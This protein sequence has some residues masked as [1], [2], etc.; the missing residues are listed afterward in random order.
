MMS[1]EIT[2]L[3]AFGGG[4][5]SFLSP[6]VVPLVPSYI[7]VLLGEHADKKSRAQL[8]ILALVFVASFSTVFILLGLSASFIGQI[9]LEHLMLLRK[10]SGIAVIILGIHLTG[11][12]KVNFL[13]REKRLNFSQKGNSYLRALVMGL[14]LS[15]AWTPCIGPVLSSILIYAG[16]SK[17]ILQ[18]G[19]MLAFYSLG[20]AIPFLLTAFLLDRFLPHFKRL[21]R[22]LPLI[23]KI[24]GLFLIIL[25]IMIYTNYLDR[26]LQYLT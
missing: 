13:H 17:T 26:I 12:I 6:C 24:A 8:M 14:A 9:L 23:Q 3:I 20:F 16:T 11:I 19:I 10:V 7:A 5:L 18:G 21:N 15:L 4:L 25:G 22:Y 2:F 1:E